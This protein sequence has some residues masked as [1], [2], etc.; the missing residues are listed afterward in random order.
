MKMIKPY[1]PNIILIDA[2]NVSKLGKYISKLLVKINSTKGNTKNI[3][4]NGI[5]VY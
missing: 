1:I 5:I 2:N 4:K 3:S